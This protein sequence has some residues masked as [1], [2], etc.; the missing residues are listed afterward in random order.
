MPMRP[1]ISIGLHRNR[2]TLD[3]IRQLLVQIMVGTTTWRGLRLRRQLI[4]HLLRDV[5]QTRIPQRST[6]ALSMCRSGNR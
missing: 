1:H 4:Q 3:W 5:F 6:W 2:Q